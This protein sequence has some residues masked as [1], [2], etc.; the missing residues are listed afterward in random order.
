[1]ATD[2][3]DLSSLV[4]RMWRESIYE[5]MSAF[6]SEQDGH[7]LYVPSGIWNTQLRKL[8]GSSLITTRMSH[9]KYY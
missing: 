4:I 9:E 5:H 7:D 1:M 8:A 2:D 3:I 6:I